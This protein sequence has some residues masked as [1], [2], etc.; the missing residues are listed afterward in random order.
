MGFSFG[1][2]I[3]AVFP[4]KEKR[5]PRVTRAQEREV[6]RQHIRRAASVIKRAV[7]EPDELPVRENVPAIRDLFDNGAQSP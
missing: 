5:K 7:K 1:P 2:I 6:T 3:R 4:N